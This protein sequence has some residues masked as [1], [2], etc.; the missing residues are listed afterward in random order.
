MLKDVNLIVATTHN[1][2]AINL[3]VKK[4]AKDLIKFGK[5]DQGI[6]NRVEMA[7]RPY[8]PCLSCVTHDLG[9]IPLRVDIV[10]SKGQIVDTITNY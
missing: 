4:A 7:L 10:D 9:R 6:L 8:D 2:A 3:S 5:Y 1:T